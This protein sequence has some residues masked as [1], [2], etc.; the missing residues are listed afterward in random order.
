MAEIEITV[1]KSGKAKVEVK[2]VAGPGCMDL[3][4]GL[5]NALGVVESLEKTAEFYEEIQVTQEVE[6]DG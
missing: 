4:R 5:E 3:A 6:L 2:G 1:L